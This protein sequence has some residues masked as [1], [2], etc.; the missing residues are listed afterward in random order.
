MTDSKNNV[1]STNPTII[2]TL[3]WVYLIIL[4]CLNIIPLG[5]EINSGLSGHNEL[6]IRLD[7]IV[8]V[9]MFLGFA[10]IYIAG[11]IVK[12]PIFQTKAIL[13]ISLITIF[14]AIMLE[15]VQ[16]FLRDRVYNPVDMFY[17]IIGTFTGILIICFSSKI[18]NYK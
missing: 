15:Y 16:N 6:K 9:I 4:I 14:A 1:A 12:K 3:F 5:K 2:N 8:H 13:K 10:W 18:T 7:Y 17:N 11:E